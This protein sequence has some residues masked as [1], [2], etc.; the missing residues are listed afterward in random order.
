M[1]YITEQN[2]RYMPFSKER[3][4]FFESL[5]ASE[6]HWFFVQGHDAYVQGLYVPAISSLL[7]GIEATLR[8]TLHQIDSKAA[9]DLS[10]LSPYRVLSNKL[11]SQANELGLQIEYLAFNDENDFLEKLNSK[12]AKPPRRRNC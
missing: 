10:E 8:I 4:L 2:M 9:G 5:C 3:N 1:D 11:I 7:N 6:Q 12:K